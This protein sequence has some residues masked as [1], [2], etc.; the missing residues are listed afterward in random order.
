MLPSFN[1]NKENTIFSFDCWNW[2][3]ILIGLSILIVLQNTKK[4]THYWLIT[5]LLTHSKEPHVYCRRNPFRCVF[6]FRKL[7]HNTRVEVNISSFNTKKKI[8]LLSMMFTFFNKHI[9]LKMVSFFGALEISFPSVVA[10]KIIKDKLDG[11]WSE[12][13]NIIYSIFRKMYGRHLHPSVSCTFILF[14]YFFNLFYLI[15]L[16]WD[17]LINHKV[18]HNITICGQ[19]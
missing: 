17:I 13:F 9:S 4:C 14:F 3:L 8:L 16:Q 10:F 12:N 19:V 18:K 7:S 15:I 1:A 11:K 2:M 6:G 5:A